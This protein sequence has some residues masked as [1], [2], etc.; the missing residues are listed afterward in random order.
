MTDT[1]PGISRSM[2]YGS[3]CDG[4]GKTGE[5]KTVG[6]WS[7]ARKRHEIYVVCAEAGTIKEDC[8]RKLEEILTN[9]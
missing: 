1:K 3:T 4:C 9:G 8:R 6:R 7:T 2:A 5:T